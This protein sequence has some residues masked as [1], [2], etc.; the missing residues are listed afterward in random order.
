MVNFEHVIVSWGFYMFAQKGVKLLNA[1]V[2]F[3]TQEDCEGIEITR[4]CHVIW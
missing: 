2:L 4:E 3:V 1:N